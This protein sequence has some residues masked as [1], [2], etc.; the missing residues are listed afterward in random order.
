MLDSRQPYGELWI[1][2]NGEPHFLCH[3]EGE[4]FSEAKVAIEKFIAVLQQQI[5]NEE[6]CPYWEAKE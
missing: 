6:H 2:K 1:D 4:N 5:D 3:I